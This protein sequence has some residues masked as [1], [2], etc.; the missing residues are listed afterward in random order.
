M[1]ALRHIVRLLQ[2]GEVY[3]P[4]TVS[5]RPQWDVFGLF[6]VCFIGGLAVCAWMGILFTRGL[7]AD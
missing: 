1:V 2:L 5:I 3:T 6:L 4:A 7:K